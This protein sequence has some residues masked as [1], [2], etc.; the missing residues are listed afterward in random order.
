MISSNLEKQTKRSHSVAERALR[1]EVVLINAPAL[2]GSRLMGASVLT[3]SSLVFI[4]EQKGKNSTLLFLFLTKISSLLLCDS[5]DVCAI[6][7]E[8]RRHH[9]SSRFPANTTEKHSAASRC[10]Y[11]RPY[12]TPV[13]FVFSLRLCLSSV[14]WLSAKYLPRMG[15]RTTDKC[16]G[17]TFDTGATC[18]SNTRERRREKN[19]TV[20]RE[21]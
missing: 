21:K 15:S 19:E 17:R 4:K 14:D 20:K 12:R 7:L 18:L 11:S 10:L 16:H 2:N 3:R 5:S 1:G 9:P 13:C 6:R 8:L